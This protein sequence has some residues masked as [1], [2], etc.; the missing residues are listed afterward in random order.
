M[1]RNADAN[2][3]RKSKRRRPDSN[4]GWRFC[5]PLP[6]HLATAPGTANVMTDNGFCNQFRPAPAA[7]LW[8]TQAPGSMFREPGSHRVPRACSAPLGASSGKLRRGAR[9]REPAPSTSHHA[10]RKIEVGTRLARPSFLYSDGRGTAGRGVRLLRAHPVPRWHVDHT[11]RVHERLPRPE[12][13][14]DDQPRVLPGVFRE[15]PARP[16]SQPGRDSVTRSRR[17]LY[18]S[19]L[20]ASRQ[21]F[22]A[23][24]YD[25]SYHALMAALHAAQDRED[26]DRLEEVAGVASHHQVELNARA[27]DHHLVTGLRGRTRAG[28]FDMAAR[29]ARTVADLI[30]RRRPQAPG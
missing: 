27:P 10:P 19:L 18:P 22:D 30:R 9:P 14:A 16:A 5:R 7:A 1:A 29:Q 2:G 21:T 24:C 13:L 6:Y 20:S 8:Q 11:G 28:L 23:G 12:W 26:T 25:T 3:R 17:D 4:R 15:A